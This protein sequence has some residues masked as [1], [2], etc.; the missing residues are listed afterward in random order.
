[1][2]HNNAL[3]HLERFAQRPLCFSCRPLPET[4]QAI[5]VPKPSTPYPVP[6]DRIENHVS[7]KL[8]SP[9]TAKGKSLLRE[10][11]GRLAEQF[12]TIYGMHNG[13]SLYKD[14]RSKL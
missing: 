1:M 11:V 8:N 12:E 3:Q 14:E 7:H 4:S 5:N 9:V 6:T 10:H 2:P 13:F